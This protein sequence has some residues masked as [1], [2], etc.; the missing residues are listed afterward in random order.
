MENKAYILVQKLRIYTLSLGKKQKPKEIFLVLRDGLIAEE[1]VQFEKSDLLTFY[2]QI[3]M[4]RNKTL[5]YVI[6]RLK[7]FKDL[8]SDKKRRT[9]S[10]ETRNSG[11]MRGMQC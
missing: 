5:A 2:C 11:W 6:D 9:R 8:V 3:W 7:K 4:L 10:L 1:Q